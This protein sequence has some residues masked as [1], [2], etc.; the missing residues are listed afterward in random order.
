MKVNVE[1]LVVR[2]DKIPY[3]ATPVQDIYDRVQINIPSEYFTDEDLN[4]YLSCYSLEH[5]INRM[6]EVRNLGMLRD[7]QEAKDLGC[8]LSRVSIRIETRELEIV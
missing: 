8:N 1:L 3:Y 6:E 7:E 4:L 2:V 5:R